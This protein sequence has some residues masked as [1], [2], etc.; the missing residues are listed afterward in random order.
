MLIKPANRWICMCVCVFVL[1]FLMTKSDHQMQSTSTY[2]S[3]WVFI[4]RPTWL[5]STRFDLTRCCFL[6][7][8]VRFLIKNEEANERK[9]A[10]STNLMYSLFFVSVTFIFTL[11]FFLYVDVDGDDGSMTELVLYVLLNQQYSVWCHIV[12][13][14]NEWTRGLNLNVADVHNRNISVCSWSSREGIID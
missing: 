14:R 9:K 8:E 4:Y 3:E 13:N 12:D 6:V 1:F 5:D 11:F 7:A 10:K 2:V